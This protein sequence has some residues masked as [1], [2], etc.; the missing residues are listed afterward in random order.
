MNKEYLKRLDEMLTDVSLPEPEEIETAIQTI[1][2]HCETA[3]PMNFYWM[4]SDVA[5]KA[6]IDKNARVEHGSVKDAWARWRLTRT[7]PPFH[8]EWGRYTASIAAY[9]VQNAEHTGNEYTREMRAAFIALTKCSSWFLFEGGAVI[10]KQPSKIEILPNGIIE[11]L[12]Y[13]DGTAYQLDNVTSIRSKSA[14]YFVDV[15]CRKILSY[16]RTE[17]EQQDVSSAD[18]GLCITGNVCGYLAVF[19]MLDC[20][21]TPGLSYIYLIAGKDGPIRIRG[22]NA[23]RSIGVMSELT[24]TGILERDNALSMYLRSV[25]DKM[26]KI[27]Y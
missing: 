12:E 5:A 27:E 20:K 9:L 19:S 13:S 23:M 16:S 15:D 6:F 3:I 21:S 17:P 4:A 1:C 10:I 11:K 8:N 7:K 22:R 25:Q 18:L 26:D 24:V 14:E 2:A